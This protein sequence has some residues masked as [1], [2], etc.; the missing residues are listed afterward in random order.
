MTTPI[1]A[2]I[3]LI[4][5][6]RGEKGCPW[7]RA[8]TP[9]SIAVYLIEEV[10]E[11]VDALDRS[12]T[13]A[14]CDELGDVLFH[15]LFI[16][17]LFQEQGAFDID[18]AARAN[19]TKMV[20]RHPHV[21]GDTTVET[22]D[23][24]RLRWQEIKAREN[25]GGSHSSTL[26]AVPAN[27]PALMRSYRVSQKAAATGF[28][29]EDLKG[30]LQKAEEEW[31]ELKTEIQRQEASMAGRPAVAEEFGDLMFTLVN[32]ARFLRVHPE[33]AL[34]SAINKFTVRFKRL[35]K[36]VRSQGR[37]LDQ[38]SPEELERIWQQIKRE[39]S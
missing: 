6:L 1:A 4:K 18:Q 3:E 13:H 30:V 17:H 31:A 27:Q 9:T 25:S 38:I 28:D 10:Y 26:D 23:E 33:T 15:V 34:L 16:A 24:V 39:P 14:I 35:E 12:D 19:H 20:R 22:A 29:W 8:Q 11:L 32:V 5:A 21:F 2:L 36:H 37:R 7:D